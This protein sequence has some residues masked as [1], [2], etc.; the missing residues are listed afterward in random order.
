MNQGKLTSATTATKLRLNRAQSVALPVEPKTRSRHAA[1]TR[2]LYSYQ[3][4]K[5]WVNN[6]R[7]TWDKS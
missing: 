7:V 2:D 4:Y 1:I 5:H 3:R 6:L